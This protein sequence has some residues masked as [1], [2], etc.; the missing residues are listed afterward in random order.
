MSVYS[1]KMSNQNL[2]GTLGAYFIL[3]VLIDFHNKIQITNNFAHYLCFDI[4]YSNFINCQIM[5]ISPIEIYK[6]VFIITFILQRYSN[7]C[8]YISLNSDNLPSDLKAVLY[9]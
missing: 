7:L 2:F 4:I 6:F 8:S 5:N 1:P 3:C 9:Y